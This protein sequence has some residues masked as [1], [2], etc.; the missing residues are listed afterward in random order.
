[1]RLLTLLPHI[2]SSILP[3]FYPPLINLVLHSCIFIYFRSIHQSIRYLLLHP[4]IHPLPPSSSINPSATSF[5]I[6]QSICYLL[7]HPSIHLLPLYS[8]INPSATSLFI[9]QSIGYLLIHPSIHRLPLDSFIHLTLLHTPSIYSIYPPTIHTILFTI[10]PSIIYLPSITLHHTPNSSKPRIHSPYLSTHL[11]NHLNQNS[12]PIHLSSTSHSPIHLPFTHPPPIHPSTSHSP[13]PLP[14][15]HPPPIHPFI[16]HLPPSTSPSS[17]I[18]H[19]I[20]HST[21]QP[22]INERM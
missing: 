18:H 10:N 5:F 21:H 12:I 2:Y 9:H 19:P 14:F 17:P 7:L 4:S 22:F 15:T 1:M 3:S 20:H 16:P 8:S 11:S 13:I 6:H